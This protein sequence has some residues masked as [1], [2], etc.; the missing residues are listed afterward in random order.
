MLKLRNF[1]IALVVDVLYHNKTVY[2]LH[3]NSFYTIG[4]VPVNYSSHLVNFAVPTSTEN[5]QTQLFFIRFFIQ[6]KKISRIYKY[7]QVLSY[8]LGLYKY[9]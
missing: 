7:N 4:L 3:R 2:Y 6:I 5:L 1:N 8:W 9:I